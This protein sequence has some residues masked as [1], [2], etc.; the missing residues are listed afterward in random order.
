MIPVMR[1][2]IGHKVQPN[3]DPKVGPL[4]LPVDHKPSLLETQTQD[5]SRFPVNHCKPYIYIT[6]SAEFLVNHCTPYTYT[7]D[8]ARSPINNLMPS[9]YIHNCAFCVLPQ[10]KGA[11]PTK[12]LCPLTGRTSTFACTAAGGPPGHPNPRFQTPKNQTPKT[13]FLNRHQGG[14]PPNRHTLKDAQ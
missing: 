6:N 9:T 8:F 13:S 14:P 2:S 1:A 7:N 5:S 11:H 10:P 3:D 12:P 4:E